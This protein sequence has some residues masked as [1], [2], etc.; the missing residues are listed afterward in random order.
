MQTTISALGILILIGIIF[1]FLISNKN[2]K[3]KNKITIFKATF[4]KDGEEDSFETQ[5]K[6][7]INDWIYKKSKEGCL[8]V[9]YEE[10]DLL[11]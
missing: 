8:L 11:K 6:K 2:K 5:N 10:K 7:L 4:T 9:K 1:Y 3:E